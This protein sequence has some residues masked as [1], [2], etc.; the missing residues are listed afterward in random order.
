MMLDQ[1]LKDLGRFFDNV[2]WMPWGWLGAV[3]GCVAD[4]LQPTVW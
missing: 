3:A 2:V 4:N 1:V